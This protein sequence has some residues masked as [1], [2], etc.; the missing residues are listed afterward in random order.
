[1]ANNNPIHNNRDLVIEQDTIGPNLNDGDIL[2][3]TGAGRNRFGL[4][5]DR[6]FHVL[7]V[8]MALSYSQHVSYTFRR[9]IEFSMLVAVNFIIC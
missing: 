1:M 4:V 7:L 5:R 6:L 3:N 8:K 2:N 9:I